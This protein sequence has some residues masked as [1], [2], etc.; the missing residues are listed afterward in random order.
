MKGR[1]VKQKKMRP[2]HRVLAKKYVRALGERAVESA[3]LCEICE[4]ICEKF[5]PK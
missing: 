3:K 2:R 5:G 1:I 4:K